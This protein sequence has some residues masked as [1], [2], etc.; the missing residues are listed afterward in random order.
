MITEK[1]KKDVSDEFI[2]LKKSLQ[3]HLDSG[4]D[5]SQTKQ[6]LQ[7]HTPKEV[8]YKSEVLLDTL[9]N[10]L[11]ADARDRIKTADVKLQNAFFDVDLRKR[12]HEWAGMLNNQLALEPNTV[13]YTFDP[14]LK[15]G[16]IASGI[17][18]VMGTSVTL[19]VSSGIVGTIVTGIITIML[20]VFSFKVTY[21]K[22]SLQARDTV[23]ADID[24]YLD[25]SQKQVCE[26]L[27]KVEATFEKD[28]HNFCSANGFS[29]E[30][31]SND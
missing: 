6:F 9:L 2:N 29:L 11:M 28:F 3:I 26:W 27:V 8:L 5:L 10:Y 15:Q 25:M 23:K 17:A 18:F 1:I 13:E 7:T 21:N 16:L 30:K 12:I 31:D 14:R 24:Q 4:F 22:A 19:T 20:S